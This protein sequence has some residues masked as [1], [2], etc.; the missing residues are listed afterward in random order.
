MLDYIIKLACVSIFSSYGVLQ[1]AVI[2]VPL[3]ITMHQYINSCLVP[4]LVLSFVMSNLLWGSQC[5]VN[6]NIEATEIHSYCDRCTVVGA[7]KLKFCNSRSKSFTISPGLIMPQLYVSSSIRR[8]IKFEG[9]LKMRGLVAIL[10]L[11][12][13]V[14][15]NPGPKSKL[16]DTFS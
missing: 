4:L 16:R 8:R 12:G 15:S 2:L 10:L 13:G 14:E 11:L 6:S 3:Y 5:H 9:H 7:M 1:P